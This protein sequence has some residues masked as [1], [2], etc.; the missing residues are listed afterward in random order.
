MTHHVV[1]DIP[2]L[3]PPDR[4]AASPGRILSSAAPKRGR[5]SPPHAA[6]SQSSP[7]RQEGYMM[8][9]TA[10]LVAASNAVL[11]CLIGVGGLLAACGAVGSPRAA[12]S[13][14][15]GRR[16]TPDL[17]RLASRRGSRGVPT[18]ALRTDAGALPSTARRVSRL[19]ADGEPSISGVGELLLSAT[20]HRS[21][22]TGWIDDRMLARLADE[23]HGHRRRGRARARLRDEL[24]ALDS[25]HWHVESDVICGGVTTPFVTFGPTGV[26]AFT[27]SHEWAFTDLAHLDRLSKD[28]SAM[29]AGYPDPVRTGLYLPLD[30]PARAWFDRRGQGGWI[31]GRGRLAEFFAHFD[32]RGFSAGELTTLR[33]HLALAARRRSR[34]RMR[35]RHT[36]G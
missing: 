10:D 34:T 24:A 6:G 27:A 22:A 36:R 19:P 25:T 5:G 26:F 33:T 3:A 8:F 1:D 35:M 14:Q 17:G 7:K 18:A 32:D 13:Q 29:I 11:A 31:V 28:L 12:R 21:P 2:P 23:L 16:V 15:C 30:E 20:S 4:I 9:S